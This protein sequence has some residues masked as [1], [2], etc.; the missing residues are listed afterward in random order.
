[1]RSLLFIMV[2][3]NSPLLISEQKV[4]VVSLLMSQPSEND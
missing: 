3:P 1:M 2:I 4:D